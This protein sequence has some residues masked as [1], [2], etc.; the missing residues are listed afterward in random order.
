MTGNRQRVRA[1]LEISLRT[2][3]KRFGLLVCGQDMITSDNDTTKEV[4]SFYGRTYIRPVP[5]RNSTER[6]KSVPVSR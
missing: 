3:G 6:R 4:Y 1:I 2:S 5:P